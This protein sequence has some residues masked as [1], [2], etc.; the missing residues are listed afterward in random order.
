MSY[1]E[2]TFTL[3]YEKDTQDFCVLKDQSELGEQ[4]SGLGHM[5][6]RIHMCM[7]RPE[8][9]WRATIWFRSYAEEDT[10]MYEKTRASLASNTLVDPG[11]TTL[12]A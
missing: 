6:R 11:P 1:D 2:N 7:K 4:Q 3:S 12:G 5:R 10:Y 9:A 8:R